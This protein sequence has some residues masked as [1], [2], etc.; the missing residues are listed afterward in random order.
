MNPHYFWAVR[1]PDDIKNIINEKMKP[2][3]VV[4]PFK[5]W[6]HPM[7]YHITLA[8]LGS[9]E[10]ERIPSL[11]DIMGAYIKDSPSF[12]LQMTGLGVF[13]NATAPRIFWVS[14]NQ[15]EMLYS[16][17]K[18]VTIACKSAGFLLESRSYNPHIT[19]ARNWNG[20]IFEKKMLDEYNP[21]HSI[22]G[23]FMVDEVVLYKT[24][25]DQTPKYEPIAT[26]SLLIE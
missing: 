16:L 1:L 10:K 20:T 8:F 9:V 21:F 19:I 11:L 6:V 12:S 18:N 2:L 17:H 14:V 25:M 4:F 23:M 3:K 24:N 22:T 13:G 15:E 26:F 7:D 5:R